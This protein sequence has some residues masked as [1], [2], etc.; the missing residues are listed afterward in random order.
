VASGKGAAFYL[1]PDFKGRR[2]FGLDLDDAIF[3]P[4]FAYAMAT[5]PDRPV[6]EAVR[7]LLVQ[8]TAANA[9]DGAILGARTQAYRETRNAIY[10][11]IASVLKAIA[12][13]MEL[14][15]I[16][17][18]DYSTAGPGPENCIVIEGSGA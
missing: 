17:D 11:E 8:A 14:S 2:A 6:Q 16:P 10:I 7:E 4:V 9:L 15:Q 12:A 13:R 5:G 1:S 3:D 18:S